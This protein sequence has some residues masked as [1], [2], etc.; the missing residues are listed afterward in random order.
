[1][2]VRPSRIPNFVAQASLLD[3]L[4]NQY[5]L[6]RHPGPKDGGDVLPYV[7]VVPYDSRWPVVF[8]VEKQRI[9]SLAG[10]QIAAVEHFGS[11]AIPR[12]CAK[13]CID[14]LVGLKDWRQAGQLKRDFIRL[15]Y[16]YIAGLDDDWQILGRTGS[17]AFRLHMLPFQNFRWNGFL[18]LRDYLRSNPRVA[19]EYC[20]R[21]KYLAVMHHTN[22]VQYSQGKRDFLDN[23]EDLARENILASNLVSGR[24]GK[25]RA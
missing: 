6:P 5:T 11:T 23:V 13:P 21:K 10:D 2:N 8:E 9:A 16:R 24:K 17:P 12:I 4:W 14:M 7:K 22:R 3:P 19:A 15:D 25:V 18:A 20:R 1:M